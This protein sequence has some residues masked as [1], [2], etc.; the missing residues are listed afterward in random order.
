L[1]V[2]DKL[3]DGVRAGQSR[4]LVVRGELGVG[5]TALLDCLAGRASGCRVRAA[6]MQSEMELAFATLHQVCAPMLDHAERLPAPQREALRTAFGI[7]TGPTSK[8]FLIGVAVLALLSEV[9]GEQPLVCGIDDAQWLD[10]ASVQALGFVARRLAAEPVGLVFAARDP[11]RE[12]AGLPALAVAGLLLR[13]APRLEPLSA[14][15]ARETHL[16]ALAAIWAGDL[17]ITGGVR[18]A[19]EAARAAPPGPDPPRAVDVLLDAVALRFTEG[20]C[21]RRAGPCP[22][23]PA[24]RPGGWRRR[25]RPPAVARRPGGCGR[26]GDMTAMIS[27]SSAGAHGRM[28]WPERSAGGEVMRG[29]E[30]EQKLIR[31]LLRRTQRGAGGVLLVEGEPGIGKSLLLRDATDEAAD[32]GFPLAAGAAD[33]LGRAIPFFALRAAL[34]EPFAE[35]IGDDPGH[36]PPTAA[37]WCITQVRA[38]LEQRAA[39]APVLVCL[40]D[41]HWASPATLAA[42]RALPRDLKRH[43]VAW[44]LARSSTPQRAADY[45]FGQLEKDGAARLTMAPLDQDAVAAM[46]TDA[47][48]APPDRALADLARGAAGNPSLVAE[49]I[50]GLRDEHAVQVTG[51]LAVLASARL[52]Q[53]IHRLAQRRLDGLSPPARHLLV[54]A[55]VLGPE[56]RLE[57]A[58]EMLGET[59][60]TLLSAVQEAMDAAIMTAAEHAFTFRHPLLRRAVGE[61]IPRPARKALHRQYGEMLLNRGESAARAASH[62]LQAAYPGDPVSLAGLD[63]AAAQTLRTAPP[64]AADL[65]LRALE[66]TPPA[67]PDAVSRAVAAAEALTAAGRLDQAARIADDMLARPLPPTAEDRLRCAL[68]SVL[69]ASGRARDAAD[70]AQLVLARPQLPDDLRDQ[71]LTAHLQ[72]LTGLRDDLAGPVAGTIL[73]APGQH[74]SHAAAAALLARAAISWDS[75]QISDSL[76]LLRD[77]ARHGTG[78]SPDA[79]QVQP[80]L[81]LAAA[82]IDLRQLGEA[83][84]ILR[85]AD[86]PAPENIPAQAARSLLR[87]RIHL[88]GGRLADAAADAQAALAVARALGAHGYAATAHSVLAVIELHRGDLAAAAQHL[89]RRPVTG[90]QP[91]DLYARPET[92]LAEAQIIEARDGPAAALGQLRQIC[93][94]LGARPGLLAGDPALAAWLARTAL[95]AGDPGLAARAARAAQ[96]LADAHPG[97][98]ALAAAAAHSQG[99]A[100]RDPGLL[101]EAATQHPDPWARASAA[102]DLGVL[103]ARQGDRDQAI[104]Y[105]RDTLGGYRQTDADRD[106]ARTRRRLRQL[107]IRRRHWSTT[108]ARPVTG[109]DSLT[110]T[111]QAVAALVAQG[112]NNNQVAARMYIS[113][114]TVAHH[115]RQA[116]RKLSITCRVELTRIVIEQAAAAR[117]N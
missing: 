101:A 17:H 81:A 14:A 30:P 22:G 64:T 87:A 51:G 80:L 48:G 50:G 10:R 42:L 62:L 83:E 44:L 39:V 82:L 15:Q 25:S 95:A 47:F 61:M 69:C 108:P 70:Q 112:L 60:A 94:D 41:L 38:H 67:D 109:W 52:P 46:F 57:D 23:A 7:S 33:Q 45:L 36:G 49:L 40:D 103:H 110:R 92:T 107:G 93:A 37:A 6:G 59:P 116:Y 78:I 117:R 79:R 9:A 99:L 20:V 16:E 66:L 84:D 105:L 115:L 13:A 68:S 8:Q 27:G 65:A 55:A 35:L 74:D 24:S 32:Q 71:A 97:F 53:R 98:P 75:G 34:R 73:A 89:A 29:R 86:H 56:F 3:V 11:D 77:A 58:A 28:A 114:H 63:Q 88:A 21:H 1:S 4:V 43:P 85:T 106:Q 12:L 18:E 111:E 100:R 2:L 54:T 26:G 76:G 104:R 102:E 113:T 90:P 72:A 31:D 19:A 96:N 5:K 91:A